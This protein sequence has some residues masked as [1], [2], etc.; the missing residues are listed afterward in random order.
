M[1]R[2]PGPSAICLEC[3]RSGLTIV[4]DPVGYL[5]VPCMRHYNE[6]QANERTRIIT[7]ADLKALARTLFKPFPSK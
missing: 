4:S 5:H 3:W 2:G 6:S 7:K 1:K